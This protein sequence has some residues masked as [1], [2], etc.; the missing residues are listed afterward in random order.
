MNTI[1]DLQ[2]Q[3]ELGEFLGIVNYYHQFIQL[4]TD[5][6][7]TLNDL[8]TGLIKTSIKKLVWSSTFSAIKEDITR[9]T[10]LSHPSSHAPIFLIIDASATAVGAVL[11]QWV[12]R[13]LGLLT[14]FSHRLQ[15]RE[16][17]Y[18]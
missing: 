8:L 13:C 14:F 11:Q 1:C 3:L 10:L 4:A 6:L 7:Q 18:T 2:Q 15:N 9:Y 17:Q 12:D 16:L 5:T